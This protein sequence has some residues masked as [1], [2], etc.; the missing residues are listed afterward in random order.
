MKKSP[1]NLGNAAEFAGF[2]PDKKKGYQNV[3]KTQHPLGDNPMTAFNRP[4]FAAI[5]ILSGGA[6]CIISFLLIGKAS[7]DNRMDSKDPATMPSSLKQSAVYL[8]FADKGN[9]FLIAE[10]R[11][12]SNSDNPA[13][14][15]TLIVKAL[16]DGPKEELMR[17]IPE[18]TTLRAFYIAQ[19]GTAYLD[20]SN[21]ITE[22]HPGGCK[23]ELITIYSIVNSLI[24][25]IPEIEAV[26]ILLE[27]LESNTLAGHIDLKLPFRANMLLIR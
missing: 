8:Y 14:L 20:F 18:G 15:G 12:F 19:D 6:L 7:A 9:S 11:V 22:Q 10:K 21:V 23:S 27:G 25:N 3:P 24:L 17:T 16:V 26:K 1:G 4:L 5:A 13:E 2:F